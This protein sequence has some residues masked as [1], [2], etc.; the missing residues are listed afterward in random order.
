MARWVFALYKQ[1]QL[2]IPIYMF[3]VEDKKNNLVDVNKEKYT[4]RYNQ[5]HLIHYEK[6]R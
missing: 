5:K 2:Q 3:H 4:I 1:G 6:I